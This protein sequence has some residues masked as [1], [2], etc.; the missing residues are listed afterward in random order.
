MHIYAALKPDEYHVA[1]LGEGKRKKVEMKDQCFLMLS[2]YNA[3]FSFDSPSRCF[4]CHV[5][6]QEWKNGNNWS[7]PLPNTHFHR[8]SF[9]GKPLSIFWTCLMIA[10]LTWAL[11][12]LNINNELFG[13]FLF[14]IIYVACFI[15]TQWS[16]LKVLISN[17]KPYLTNH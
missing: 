1:G 12:S 5:V 2:M 9:S 15:K 17:I 6:Q 10:Y 4:K 8:S 13:N 7:A 11:N 14:I 16:V 3:N